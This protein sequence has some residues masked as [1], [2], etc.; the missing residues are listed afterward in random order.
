MKRA[1]GLVAL[2]TVAVVAT[3][4][5]ANDDVKGRC[6]IHMTSGRV[7][8]GEVTPLE[9]GVYEVKMKY[10]IVMKVPKSEILKIVALDETPDE[11]KGE[12]TPEQINP[13]GFTPRFAI[14]D[15]RVEEIL[16]GIELEVD[17]SA[18]LSIEILEE[19]LPMDEASAQEMVRLAGGPENASIL[20]Y[21]HFVLVYT[22]SKESAKSLGARLES[23][24]RWNARFISALGLTPI[25][26]ESKMEVFY[27]KNHK[28]FENYSLNHGSNLPGGVMGYFR[29]DINRSHFFDLWYMPMFDG[30]RRQLEHPR[31]LPPERRRYLR[32]YINAWVEHNNLEVIQHECGHHLHFNTGVFKPR[33][34]PAGGSAPTWLVEGA[35]MLFEVPPA[36]TGQGGAGLGE[37]NDARLD[38]FRKHFPYKMTPTEFKRFVV[39]DRVWMNGQYDYP[40]GWA[41]VYY[42]WKRHRDGLGEYIQR[43]YDRPP[44]D[45]MNFTEKE[46]EFE[47]CFGRVD[48]DWIDDFYDFLKSLQVRQSRLPPEL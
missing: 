38:E 23:V 48:E 45:Y 31:N 34:G 30:I 22:A 14:S 18:K 11:P 9:N 13:E 16:A 2:L 47:D 6:R 12:P 43:I 32:N 42:L 3:Q 40:R 7:V 5:F 15:E 28:E 10:G 17:E 26:P 35:T 29:H 39:D 33:T 46:A 8:E 20:E 44:L 37:F 41:V 24:Y 21:P 36:T 1:I 25:R 4:A 19:P 27:F